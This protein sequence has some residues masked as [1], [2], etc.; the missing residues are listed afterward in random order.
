MGQIMK[1][2]GLKTK[3]HGLTRGERFRDAR[4]VYNRNGPQSL[5]KVEKETG[6]VTSMIQAVEDDEY[7]RNI[8]YI[9]IKELATHYG[10]SIDWLLGLSEVP[11]LEPE[12][13]IVNKVTKL[14]STAIKNIQRETE[15]ENTRIA[16]E[17]LLCCDSELLHTL[18]KT[19]YKAVA[20]Y[21]HEITSE[22]LLGQF[23][24]EFREKAEEILK[25]WDGVILEHE[26]A[27]QYN[28]FEAGNILTYMIDNSKETAIKKY[29]EISGQLEISEEYY[30]ND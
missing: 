14:S 18:C 19:I 27:M 25:N 13:K 16:L 10:V 20:G 5:K 28:S 12:M 17:V 15:S 29:H 21:F 8:S 4:T 2:S 9:R 24:P 1:N 26:D 6:L 11:S 7:D 23:Q 22:Q 3:S 30:G